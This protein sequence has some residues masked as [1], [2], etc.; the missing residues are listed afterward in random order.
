MPHRMQTWTIYKFMCEHSIWV[1]SN[2]FSRLNLLPKQLLCG[3]LE[4][5]D[6]YAPPQ[7]R[8]GRQGNL[9]QLPPQAPAKVFL[10]KLK[11]R[12]WKPCYL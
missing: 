4:R 1:T 12:Y 6:L 11:I 5:T 10:I 8:S 2:G 7:E 9:S 3:Y